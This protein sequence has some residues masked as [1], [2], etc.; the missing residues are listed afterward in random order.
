MSIDSITPITEE[1]IPVRI[2][3]KGGRPR[4]AKPEDVVIMPS[5]LDVQRAL[6]KKSF[7]AFYKAAYANV[8]EPA[9]QYKD[10]WHIE[11][12]CDVLQAEAERIHR[13]EVK[14]KDIII[15]IPFRASKSLICTV[16]FPVWCW[17]SFPSLRFITASYSASL[18][19]GLGLQSRD[20]LESDWF[21]ELFPGLVLKGDNNAKSEYENNHT[22]KRISTSV[23]GTITGKGANIIVIDDPMKPDE[24]SSPVKLKEVQDWYDG[25]ISNRLNDFDVDVR[26]IVMQRLAEEDLCGYLLTKMPHRFH[27]ICLPATDDEPDIIKPNH[28]RERYV[29]G[30]FWP[31]RFT[32]QALANFLEDMGSRK[33]ANQLMQ[34]ALPA[35]GGMF[36]E[37]WM[38]GNIITPEAFREKVAGRQLEWKLFVDGAETADAKNDATVYLL[39]AKMDKQLFVADVQWRRLVFTDLVRDLTQYLSLNKSTLYPIQKVVIEGKSVG[40]HLL[41]QMRQDVGNM[42]FTEVQPGRDSKALRA[43]AATNYVEGGR[44][45]LVKS[46]AWNDHFIQEVTSFTDGKSGHD[47]ALDTLVYAIKDAESGSFY[48]SSV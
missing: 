12:V 48:Y 26:I 19:L 20:L 47:D 8:L 32:R 21:K 29:D 45:W 13:R 43:M 38:S 27:H 7:Y 30:L 16:A 34:K 31:N 40:K 24:A 35:D 44:L 2:K 1:V 46:T 36:K 37:A 5:L 4:K 28:L 14:A 42:V 39:C 3:N 11:Y 23:G 15:N 22:G 41:R 33:Y 10:N 17:I 18:S 25:T 6:Y 9:S